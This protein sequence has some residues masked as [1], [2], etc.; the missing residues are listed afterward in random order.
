M[1]TLQGRSLATVEQ[2]KATLTFNVMKLNVFGVPWVKKIAPDSRMYWR[3]LRGGHLVCLEGDEKL[4]Y[5]RRASFFSQSSTA[6]L[7]KRSIALLRR[8]GW[9]YIDLHRHQSINRD[10]RLGYISRNAF[11][12]RLSFRSKIAWL[13]ENIGSA[14]RGI[15][16]IQKTSPVS[17]PPMPFL[18]STSAYYAMARGAYLDG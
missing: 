17:I 3:K 16:S 9:Y 14:R 2:H 5:S 1:V 10:T 11:C 6:I 8:C 18:R 7:L 4:I 12:F 13:D 15:Y